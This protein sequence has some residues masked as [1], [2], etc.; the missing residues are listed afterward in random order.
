MPQY[1]HDARVMMFA[2]R[3]A[4]LAGDD[5]KALGYYQTA[6]SSEP[7]HH[8]QWGLHEEIVPIYAALG[9]KDN[10]DRERM[11]IREAAAMDD[12]LLKNL[13]GYVIEEIHQDG[14]VIQVWEFPRLFGRFHTRYRFIYPADAGSA[15]K[16][17]ID[18]E[19]DDI[20]QVSFRQKHPD[21]AAKG[22]RSFSLDSYAQAN[23]HGTL[24]FFEEGEPV[25]ETVRA[26]VLKK[27]EP[28][29]TTTVR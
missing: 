9:D 1:P 18:C 5:K 29:A 8:P 28:L 12:P 2:G 6:L 24:M 3:A 13:T 22:E 19:S 20:D 11:K 7:P 27:T 17:F 25:Y 16:P 23:S 14:K 21:L 4:R 15:W 10:F 26:L